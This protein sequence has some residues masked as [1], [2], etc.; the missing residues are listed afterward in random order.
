MIIDLAGW[1]GVTPSWLRFGVD[2][3]FSPKMRPE[4]L[5]ASDLHTVHAM[6][7]LDTIGKAMVKQLLL[8]LC[9]WFF[10]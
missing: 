8:V 9:F 2:D 7:H 5:F 1:P 4:V 6:Q 3:E 10:Y